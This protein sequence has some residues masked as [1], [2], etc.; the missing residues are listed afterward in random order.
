[1]PVHKP[2][3][4]RSARCQAP[5]LLPAAGSAGRSGRPQ[6]APPGSCE[7]LQPIPAT[8]NGQGSRASAQSS[9][10]SGKCELH[11]HVPSAVA[12]AP[13]QMSMASSSGSGSIVQLA[14]QRYLYQLNKR[15][16][17][18]KALTSAFIAALAD[19]IAQRILT[20][21]Y[22]S[23]KRTL[24]CALWGLIWNGPSAH[25]WWVREGAACGRIGDGCGWQMAFCQC[26]RPST[27]D[28]NKAGSLAAVRFSCPL[29][30]H[31]MRPT[32][33]PTAGALHLTGAIR[34]CPATVCHVLAG[35]SSWRCCFE[36]KATW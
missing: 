1:M 3:L 26:F 36:G 22:K 10:D 35:R 9:P 8:R 15:P 28:D 23:P 34:C 2:M 5:A 11:T 16:L 31:R 4:M 19:V 18:T 21:G 7:P 27:G 14:W 20:G 25:Y 6:R 12:N 33:T 29:R 13:S 24:A 17:R 30:C 32:F